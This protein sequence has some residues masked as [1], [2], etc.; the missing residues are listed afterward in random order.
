MSAGERSSIAAGR[1]QVHCTSPPPPPAAPRTLVTGRRGVSL[2]GT[3]GGAA[4]A[5]AD[6]GAVRGAA[7][8][9]STSSFMKKKAEAIRK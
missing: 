7:S 8:W 5:G 9:A 4:H 2:G 3:T 1:R 6:G